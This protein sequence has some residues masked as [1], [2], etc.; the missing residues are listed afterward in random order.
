M[1]PVVQRS[2]N[3]AQPVEQRCGQYY[4]LE[5]NNCLPKVQNSIFVKKFFV[6]EKR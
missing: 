6:E 4:L 3:Q 2:A 5:I 1:D